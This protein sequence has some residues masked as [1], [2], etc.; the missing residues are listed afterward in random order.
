MGA[1]GRSL[2]QDILTGTTVTKETIDRLK[3][4]AEHIEGDVWEEPYNDPLPEWSIIFTVRFLEE[5][6]K[7]SN[8][9]RPSLF[10]SECGRIQ[11]AYDEDGAD[12]E[13]P[14]DVSENSPI[15]WSFEF[16]SDDYIEFR[17]FTA[18][19][20]RKTGE[21]VHKV[22]CIDEKVT[23]DNIDTIIDIVFSEIDAKGWL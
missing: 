4:F 19:M 23:E 6:S 17:I 10:L 11:I 7:R 14:E 9:Q 12:R 18:A 1:K 20:S 16:V 15:M 2:S 5:W 8:K 21:H 13:D 22:E 3:N